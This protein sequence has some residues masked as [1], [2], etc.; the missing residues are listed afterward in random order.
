[1]D[2][3]NNSPRRRAVDAAAARQRVKG[4]RSGRAWTTRRSLGVAA[5][6]AGLFGSPA[7][8]ARAHGPAPAPLEVLGWAGASPGGLGPQPAD[9][10]FPDA[11]RTSVG[12]VFSLPD[13]TYRA[14]CPTQWGDVASA[15]A[16][17][18]PGRGLVAVTAL[19]EAFVSLDGGCGLTRVDTSGLFIIGV[20]AQLARVWLWGRVMDPSGALGGG[21]LLEVTPDGALVEHHRWSDG[22]W[23]DDVGAWRS[24][25]GQTQGL[26]VV[27]ARGA[28]ALWLAAQGEDGALRWQQGPALPS[29][30]STPDTSLARLSLRAATAEG[31]L[32]LQATE[33]AQRRL[34]LATPDAASPISDPSAFAGGRPLRW[35]LDAHAPGVEAIYGPVLHAGRWWAV[36]DGERAWFPDPFAPSAP[37]DLDAISFTTVDEVSWTCLRQLE[38]VTTACTL[39]AM[40]HVVAL[41][42]PDDPTA[43]PITR[44]IFRF[45]NLGPPLVGCA[46]S[47]A[48]A[49]QCDADWSHYGGE[50]GFIE[51]PAVSV[52][53]DL[54]P[55]PPDADPLSDLAPT[56]ADTTDNPDAINTPDTDPTPAPSTSDDTSP[57][58]GCDLTLPRRAGGF[59]WLW[60]ALTLGWVAR[61]LRGVT[62]RPR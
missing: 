39:E 7:G 24:P 60:A 29:V 9:A 40:L 26:V 13:G 31:A 53:G 56:S 32:W 38:G 16:A 58:C 36:F 28:P 62:P 59:G 42:T 25:D 47:P 51:R 18:T 30:V 5:L 8:A 21:A 45:D 22:F 1:V 37:E 50:S 4:P 15:P 48:E 44:E 11:L 49:A 35:R 19:G 52:S 2:A 10:P 55:P 3:R 61:R 54:P 27:G 6:L 20:T 23:P 17:A 33:G 57:G 34:W 12:L 46:S 41:G 43:A 14:S